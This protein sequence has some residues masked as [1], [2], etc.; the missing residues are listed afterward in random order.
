MSSDHFT[1][2]TAVTDYC[3]SLD[4]EPVNWNLQFGTKAKVYGGD[5]WIDTAPG[6]P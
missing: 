4:S 2:E 6:C 1:F 3:A 5:Y